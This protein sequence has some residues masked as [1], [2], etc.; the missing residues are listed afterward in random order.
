MHC[1]VVKESPEMRISE[2]VGP[3]PDNFPKRKLKIKSLGDIGQPEIRSH[4]Q[5]IVLPRVQSSSSFLETG[6]IHQISC[7]VG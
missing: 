7:W 5:I 3:T 2:F 6:I 4:P 1:E